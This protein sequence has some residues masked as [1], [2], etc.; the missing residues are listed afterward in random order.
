MNCLEFRRRLLA[1]PLCKDED[2]L[3]HEAECPA[4]A[5]FAQDVRAKEIRLR[6]ILQAVAPRPG[7]AERI[8]LAAG[9]E[10]RAATRRRWWY[11]AAASVLLAI[12]V[13]MVSLM[14]TSIERGN[15]ALA[16]S[17][18]NHIED[19]AHHL[20]EAQALPARRVNLVFKRFGAKL[21]A[22]IG[23]VNFAAE[24]LMR[25][26]NGVHLVLPGTAGPITVFF[27]PGETPPG[28]LSV[29]SPRF[30]GRILPTEWG[31]IAVVGEQGERLDG[32]GERLAAAVQW[33]QPQ[34][35]VVE[36]TV[37]GRRLATLARVTQQQDG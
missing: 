1:D 33:P 13:S 35:G 6:S 14:N 12:G 30:Q 7:M 36:S 28:V 23:P 29:S 3:A 26:R 18:V 9:F 37:A 8:Q 32:I 27:M 24:C 5:P 10:R 2:L 17:V 22:D 21:A 31:S 25:N 15:V 20:R 16:Q 4:C 11:G 19:E 34:A